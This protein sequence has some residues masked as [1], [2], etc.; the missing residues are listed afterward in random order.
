[1]NK[2][3]DYTEKFN[4]LRGLLL[5]DIQEHLSIAKAED[6]QL[7]GISIVVNAIDDQFSQTIDRVTNKGLVV[8]ISYGEYEDWNFENVS[9]DNL[10]LVLEKLE[11]NEFEVYEESGN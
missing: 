11:N 10:L 3:T 8:C 5:E 6:I 9:T 7:T 4:V 2:S 1:M